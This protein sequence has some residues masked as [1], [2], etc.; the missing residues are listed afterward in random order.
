VQIAKGNKMIASNASWIKKNASS[1]EP[2]GILALLSVLIAVPA[3]LM[4]GVLEP[5]LVLPG[6]SMLLFAEQRSPPSWPAQSTFTE[7]RKM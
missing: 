4:I 5:G 3:Y 6:F 7:I 1:R 2:Y